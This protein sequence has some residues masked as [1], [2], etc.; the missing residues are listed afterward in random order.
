MMMTSLQYLSLCFTYRPSQ[1]YFKVHIFEKGVVLQ[2]WMGEITSVAVYVCFHMNFRELLLLNGSNTQVVAFLRAQF[3]SLCNTST[4]IV[5]AVL[6]AREPPVNFPIFLSFLNYVLLCMYYFRPDLSKIRES[7]ENL[8]TSGSAP[9]N[10][11][12]WTECMRYMIERRYPLYILAAILDV[13]ASMLLL[14]AFQYTTVT[15]IVL[16]DSFAIPCTMVLSYFFMGAKYKRPHYI[17]IALCLLG[18]AVNVISDSLRESGDSAIQQRALLGDL[19]CLMAYSLYAVSNVLQEYLVKYVDR[20]EYMGMLGFWGSLLAFVQLLVVEYD[21]LMSTKFDAP[22]V[23][24]V[25]AY[26]SLLFL[27][28]INASIVLQLNDATYFNLSLLTSDVYAL[29]LTYLVFG[30]EVSYL[31]FV[32]FIFIVA[33]VLTYHSISPATATSIESDDCRYEE[34]EVGEQVVSVLHEDEQMEGILVDT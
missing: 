3:V 25:I 18:L 10:K 4:G 21:D 28:Y 26:V 34:V 11:P 17:G 13:E 14:T 20:E 16:L 33:G 23:G 32:A 5:A 24:L 30:T 15:S 7:I 8:F 31:Y 19:F 2:L 27:F 6:A 9:T 1:K 29:L 12:S 22:V